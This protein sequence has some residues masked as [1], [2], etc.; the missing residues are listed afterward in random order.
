MLKSVNNIYKQKSHEIGNVVKKKCRWRFEI[1]EIF[2]N[3]L[4][5]DPP[6]ARTCESGLSLVAAA[7]NFS[8]SHGTPKNAKNLGCVPACKLYTY[9]YNP[10]K[11][12]ATV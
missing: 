10:S 9:V 7:Q 1:L 4:R 11:S 6:T 3:P 5:R 12:V 2:S 8:H